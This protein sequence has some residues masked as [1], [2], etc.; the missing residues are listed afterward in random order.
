MTQSTS[1]KENTR[2][3]TRKIAVFKNIHKTCIRADIPSDAVFVL[4]QRMFR[5]T[6]T[7]LQDV[8]RFILDK[9]SVCPII[10]YF[11]FTSVLMSAL[12]SRVYLTILRR[13]LF[14]TLQH[15]KKVM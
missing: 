15:K 9:K 1:T 13:L 2:K 12:L 5:G 3:T 14:D 10:N 4:T 11:N 8:N 6:S 7:K